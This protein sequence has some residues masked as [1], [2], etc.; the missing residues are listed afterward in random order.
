VAPLAFPARYR[1]RAKLVGAQT[2]AITFLQRFGGSLNLNLHLHVAFLDGVFVRDDGDVVFHPAPPPD[3]PELQ[4]IVCRVRK[5]ATAWLRRHGYVDEDPLEACSNEAPEQGAIEGCA[6]I[7]MQRGAFAKLA[8]ED[9]LRDDGANIDP[10]R[11]R[12]SAEHE[13]F[14]LHAGVHIAAGDDAGRERL[15][16][17]GARPPMALARLRRLPD[18]RF[19]FRVKYA[20]SGCAKYRILTPLELLARI[21]A[22]LPPPRFPLTRMHGVLAPRSSWRK[23]VVP[24]P[25]EARPFTD[26]EEKKLCKRKPHR[27]DTKGARAHGGRQMDGPMPRVRRQAV[28]PRRS[29]RRCCLS[30]PSLLTTL[31]GTRPERA[32]NRSIRSA[33]TRRLSRLRNEEVSACWLHADSR[34]ASSP[35]PTGTASWEDSSTPPPRI[36]RGRSSYAERSLWTSRYAP[37]AA[38]ASE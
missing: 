14:N 5:R 7:A 34:P 3:A 35:S 10:A 1:S 6:A 32:R 21:A 17:Y 18:G 30:R 4:G 15:F 13:G 28:R 16:R 38:A 19:A 22:I 24:K 37:S 27:D 11:L 12:S 33:F 31:P 36:C 8:T 2:G 9:G 20:R 26:R 23:D 29:L 25:R